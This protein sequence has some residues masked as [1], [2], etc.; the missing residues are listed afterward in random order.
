MPPLGGAARGTIA[1]DKG[2]AMTSMRDSVFRSCLLRGFVAAL[3]LLIAA[4]WSGTSLA[5][6]KF[7]P[8]GTWLSSSGNTVVISQRGAVIDITI[9]IY[10]AKA[11]A[12]G[13]VAGEEEMSGRVICPHPGSAYVSYVLQGRSE[14][15]DGQLPALATLGKFTVKEIVWRP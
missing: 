6:L 14:S 11:I 13:C 1:G 4:A 8:N 5:R 9:T 10:G 2:R 7:D 12:P 15:P 3:G